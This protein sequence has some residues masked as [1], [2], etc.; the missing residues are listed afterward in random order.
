MNDD[1]PKPY[2]PVAKNFNLPDHNNI[3][4][5]RVSVMKQVKSARDS[6]ATA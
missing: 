3:N 1:R 2:F 5:M 6:K 4:N